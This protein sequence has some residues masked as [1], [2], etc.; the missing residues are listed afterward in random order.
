MNSNE[1]LKSNKHYWDT[2]ADEWFGATALPIYG[3]LVPT[4]DELQ[5]FGN[6]SGKKM[7]DIGCG[8]GH[9]LKY[10]GNNNAAELWGLDMSTKQIE[11][12]KHY[13]NEC[14]YNPKLFNVPMEIDCGLP[15]NYFDIVYSIYA[16]GWTTDLQKTFDLVASYLKPGGIFIFSWDHPVMR[17]IET[18]EEKLVFEGCYFDESWFTYEKDGY[19]IS[20][21]KRRISTYINT[22][23]TAGFV[24]ERM[25]ED[26]N[27]ETLE[28]DC[29]ISTKYYAPHKAKKFPLSFI[30]KARKL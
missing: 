4:E 13:L 9:S 12:A 7:L 18:Q 14:G 24:V 8:S 6:V 20:L 21:C 25:I 11:N 19:D 17:N 10:H 22:L 5:L 2:T 15:K 29:E 26:T 28:N 1:I 16:I 3:C 23:A 27:Q 30:F